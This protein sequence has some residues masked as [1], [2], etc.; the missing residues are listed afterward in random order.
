MRPNGSTMKSRRPIGEDMLL[1]TAYA[2]R[3]H[4]ALAST[5]DYRDIMIR[6]G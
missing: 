5:W 2:A 4:T 1:P 3:E 6:S